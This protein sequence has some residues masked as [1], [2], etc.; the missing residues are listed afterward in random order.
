M[1]VITTVFSC[2]SSYQHVLITVIFMV[3]ADWINLSTDSSFEHFTITAFAFTIDFTYFARFMWAS[4]L[5]LED[6]S[7]FDSLNP[8]FQVVVARLPTGDFGEFK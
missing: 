4:C 2:S 3:L 8:L 7:S 5:I 6:Y 1:A